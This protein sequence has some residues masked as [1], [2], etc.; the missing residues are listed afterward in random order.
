MRALIIEDN[1][2]ISRIVADTLLA[3]GLAS[4]VCGNAEDGLLALL[5]VHYDVLVLDLGLP[6]M[7][8][9]DLLQQIRRG[10]AP[11]P[12]LILTARDDIK[13]RVEGL[14]HGADDYLTKPFAPEELAAR[15]RALL[16]RPG[17]ALGVELECGN[18][19]M[20]TSERN[21]KVR[22]QLVLLSRRETELLELMLRRVGRVLSKSSI[23]ESL[24]AFGEE[25]ASNSVEVCV[26]RLRK[27]LEKAEA[28]VTIHTV[29]GVGYLL[30]EIEA[31]H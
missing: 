10:K 14:N 26:H 18:V 30:S 27:S 11:I 6:D 17:G 31:V 5:A 9:L 24:Y 8:G 21:V 2:K 20:N 25:V 23:E 28:S 29:R 4:D 7:D 19:L 12:V 3:A 22:N 1:E 13:E 15:V 16:R